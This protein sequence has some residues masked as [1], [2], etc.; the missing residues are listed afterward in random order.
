MFPGIWKCTL[1]AFHTCLA[2]AS[3][4]PREGTLPEHPLHSTEFEHDRCSL[5]PVISFLLNSASQSPYADRNTVG[6]SSE[7]IHAI[8][9]EPFEV[10]ETDALQM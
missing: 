9:S 4:S 7:T 1:T 10:E 5:T 3:R 8:A 2:N 6:L